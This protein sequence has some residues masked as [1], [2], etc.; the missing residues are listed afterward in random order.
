MAVAVLK[1]AICGYGCLNVAICGFH[2]D[3]DQ[4]HWLLDKDAKLSLGQILN[5]ALQ[6]QAGET[7]DCSALD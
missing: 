5:Q 3:Y 6:A 2:F 4:N 1:V 7:L